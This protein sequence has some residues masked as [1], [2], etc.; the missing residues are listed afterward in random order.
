MTMT[1]V[2]I[3]VFQNAPQIAV[4]LGITDTIKSMMKAIVKIVVCLSALGTANIDKR[5]INM[6]AVYKIFWYEYER[7]WGRTPD[8]F[9][10][11]A[12][13]IEA[14]AYAKEFIEKNN[15]LSWA[16]DVYV[17]PEMPPV[18]VDVDEEMHKRVERKRNIRFE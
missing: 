13:L 10:Y 16:P 7:G 14:I 1:V 2:S 9:S 6:F 11:H 4:S 3:V 17:S 5:R 15:T 18:L 12:S 8:G